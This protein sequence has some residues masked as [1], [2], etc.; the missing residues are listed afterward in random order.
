MFFTTFIK[1]RIWQIVFFL[2][3]AYF[4]LLIRSDLIRNSELN[5]EKI[6][7]TKSLSAEDA[8]KLDLKI[9]LKMLNRSSFIEMLARK[10]LGVVRK[11]E[12]P[13]KVIIK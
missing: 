4:V 12:D 8:K 9:K 6:T 11:G 1:A 3:L 5:D 7:F 13:Y 10:E 2:A